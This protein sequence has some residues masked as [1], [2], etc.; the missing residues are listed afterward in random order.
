[1]VLADG[2]QIHRVLINLA[3]NAFHAM[4]ETG[5]VLRFGLQRH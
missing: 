4:E 3:T 1:M 5:G 2:V